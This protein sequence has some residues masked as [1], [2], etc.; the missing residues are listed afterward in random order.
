MK[1]KVWINKALSASLAV[2]TILAYSMVALANTEK[3]A[4][5]IIITGTNDSS[6]IVNGTTINSSRSIYSS[7]TVETPENTGA[8]INIGKIGSVK[9]A[10]KTK[11]NLSFSE[12]GISGDLLA[13][14]VTVLN[15]ADSVNIVT[16]DGKLKKLV[17]GETAV[18]N[19]VQDE[20][21]DD[22]PGTGAWFIW[23]LV[24]GGAAAGL[25]IAATNDND[26][27]VGGGTTVIS[28]T[29]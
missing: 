2:V 1:S 15:A 26:I 7:S 13:G 21:D 19:K 11:L 25:I 22:D 29:R 27:Q 28:P 3:V 20:D 12:K 8:I 16:L 18:A 6:V 4:G 9:L 24:L 10:P 17:A 14:K 5:E 23:A